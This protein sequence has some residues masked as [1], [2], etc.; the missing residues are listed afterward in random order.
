MIK[1][2]F[3]ICENKDADQLCINR[4]ADQRLCFSLHRWNN[5]ST[6]YIRNFKPLAIFCGC[7]AWFVWDL[8]GNPRPVFSQRGSY[9]EP[10]KGPKS[11]PSVKYTT[12]T[13]F[14]GGSLSLIQEEQVVTYWLKNGH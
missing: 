12:C 8:V 11:N 1:P 4:E 13:F 3:C 10:I 9:A 2:A 14:F 5:P 7:T 6:F